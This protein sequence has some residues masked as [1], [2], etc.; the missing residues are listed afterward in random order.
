M[1][2][3]VAFFDDEDRAVADVSVA[4][5]EGEWRTGFGVVAD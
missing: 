5:D 2:H 4:V 3:R 1:W